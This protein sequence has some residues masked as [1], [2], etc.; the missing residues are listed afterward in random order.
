[1]AKRTGA[2]IVMLA[3]TVLL[4]GCASYWPHGLIYTEVK[5]PAAVGN[6]GCNYSKVGKAKATS[7]LGLVAIG[8]C[9]IK[10][11][12]QNGNITNIKYVDYD[13][14]NILGFYGE[15]TTTVYGD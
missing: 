3:L 4:A 7:V 2:L 12:M 11:A 5:G 6:D 8:D 9:S 10:A 15:Y 13:A 14:R 1:M